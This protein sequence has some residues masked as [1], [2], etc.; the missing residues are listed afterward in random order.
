MNGP[1]HES[2]K[3]AARKFG[4]G[5]QSVTVSDVQEFVAAQWGAWVRRESKRHPGVST[6]EHF[7]DLC[8][9][10]TDELRALGVVVVDE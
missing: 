3:R 5:K 7:A 2:C 4:H 8:E 6:G 10:V 1:T 9:G